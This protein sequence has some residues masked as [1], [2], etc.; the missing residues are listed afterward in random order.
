[1]KLFSKSASGPEGERRG[2][3]GQLLPA[4]RSVPAEGGV[5]PPTSGNRRKG[6]VRRRTAGPGWVSGSGS[7]TT[8]LDVSAY[9]RLRDSRTCH[10]TEDCVSKSDGRGS[11][12]A[13]SSLWSLSVHRMRDRWLAP[14]TVTHERGQRSSP[15]QAR[16]YFLMPMVGLPL[17]PVAFCPA[18][19][20]ALK[21]R[22]LPVKPA[23]S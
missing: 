16:L 20:S 10:A 12:G 9:P 13:I 11:D 8:H 4:G 2:V 23:S 1:M 19:G 14:P 17:S 7:N 15:T 3:S 5:T 6:E 18:A 21:D 22:K